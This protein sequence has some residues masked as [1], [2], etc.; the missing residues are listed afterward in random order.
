MKIKPPTLDDLDLLAQQYGLELSIDDL[1]SFQ[2]LMAGPIASYE[3]ID[4]LTE[5]KPAVKY[6]RAGAIARSRA[7]T[8]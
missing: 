3:R 8:R 7:T 1:E 6:P 4:Q 5:P 2:G